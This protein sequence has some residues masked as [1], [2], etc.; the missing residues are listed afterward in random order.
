[1]S[2][3][4]DCPCAP[5][6]IPPARFDKQE[7]DFETLKDYNNYLEEVEEVNW[8][9]ILGIDVE[10]T[11][12]RLRKWEEAR[13]AEANPN[14][15]RRVNEPDT[16]QLSDT[17]HVILKKGATQR[18]AVMSLPGHTSDQAG[19][20]DDANRDTGFT[21]RGMKKRK[22]P[23]PEKPFDPFGGWDIKPQYYT[24]QHDYDHNWFSA[25]KSDP[26]HYAG[27]Y[28]MREY[29]S[30]ALCDA[31]GG[32]GIFVEDEMA[33]RGTDGAGDAN[34]DTQ[35]AATTVAAGGK[36]VDMTDIF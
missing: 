13:K 6:L 9:L 22:S 10:R 24:L 7:S 31:F 18:R 23:E 29:Y 16:S 15:I 26:L 8:N 20:G 30:R 12:Q 36:D 4:H 33:S 34:F 5:L 32:M 25:T 19:V 35:L 21:F 11:E 28:D 27:G 1:V 17:S 2:R 14:A 3:W